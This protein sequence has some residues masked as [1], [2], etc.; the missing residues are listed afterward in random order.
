MTFSNSA[1]GAS[2]ESGSEVLSVNSATGNLTIQGDGA[3]ISVATVGTVITVSFTGGSGV[4][5]SVSNSDSTLTISPTTG[6]VVASLNLSHANTWR[7][8]QTFGTNISILGIQFSGAGPTNGQVIQYN[9]TNWVAATATGAVSS[10]SNSDGTLTISPTTGAVVASIA[11]SHAN[12]W[13][14]LQTFGNNISFGGVTLNVSSLSSGQY[15][16]YNGT[17]WVNVNPI[18]GTT[19]TETSGQLALNLGN[20]NTWTAIQ[21]IPVVKNTAPQTT[22]SGTTAGSAVSSQPEQGSAYKK[23]IVYFSGYENNTS[24]SQTITYPTA[25]TNVPVITTNTASS[26]TSE[27]TFTSTTSVLTI[28]APNNT[29]TFTGWLIIEGY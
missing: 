8:V 28:T 5:T 23:F 6:A 2:I 18:T 16:Y 9:G 4:V 22:L 27:L 12:T 10:V 29:Q 13:G 24:T 14:A 1:F 7:A 20:A 26:G 17:N 25:F 21:T 19:L 11:L 15:L 3:D